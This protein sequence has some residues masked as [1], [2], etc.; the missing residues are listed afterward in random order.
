MEVQSG[1]LAFLLLPFALVLMLTL[2]QKAQL[3]RDGFVHLPGQVPPELV[4]RVLH[5]V[6]YRIGRGI[7][8]EKLTIWQAQSFFPD[9]AGDPVVTDLYNESGLLDRLRELLGEKNAV[10]LERGQLALRFPREPGTAAKPPLPHIDGIHTKTNGVKEGTLAS[11]TALVG[12]F[13]TDVTR[14]NAGNFTVWPGSHLKME[15]HFREHGIDRLLDG[16]TPPVGEGE[17][18]QILARAGDAVIAHYQL[19][20]G[21]ATNVS[22]RPRFATFF[23]VTHPQHWENRYDCLT[24]LWREWEGMRERELAEVG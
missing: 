1:V 10:P 18:H 13:L 19:L 6:Y 7:P 23:R 3:R 20:H 24:D 2:E 11:F 17:P 9:L 15:A 22:P 14:E 21:A 5:A 12:I 4:E 8:E 16:V